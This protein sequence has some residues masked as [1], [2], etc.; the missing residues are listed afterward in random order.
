MKQ[1]NRDRMLQIELR[2]ASS[3]IRRLEKEAAEERQR[4]DRYKSGM[5]KRNADYNSLRRKAEQVIRQIE[6]RARDAA[7]ESS[8]LSQELEMARANHAGIVATLKQEL[9]ERTLQAEASQG[10]ALEF[11]HGWRRERTDFTI[12]RSESERKLNSAHERA[13]LDTLEELLPVI[14][15]I[16]RALEF[17][18]DYI[19][20]EPWY[21]G[22][23]IIQ[24]RFQ[25]LLSKFEIV[26]INPTGEP[27]DPSW[28]K[29]IATVETNELA[30]GH[31]VET[32]QKGYRSGD[33]ELRPA[34]VKVAN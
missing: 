7:Q 33:N 1:S 24:R 8:E 5:R 20:D 21:E 18:P 10:K 34:L 2:Q 9:E 19:R 11:E 17:V 27:F 3:Q 6:R 30:S 31:V 16:E 23:S 25:T 32:L 15:D 28:H 26:A 12:Y 4:A 13:A 22:V 14:D 29:A